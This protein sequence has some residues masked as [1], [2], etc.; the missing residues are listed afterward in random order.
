M[1]ILLLV[2]LASA[3]SGSGAG[4]SGDPYQITNCSQLQE[5]E[6]SLSSYYKLVNDIDCSDTINWDSGAGFDPIPHG[7]QGQLSGNGHKIINLFINRTSTPFGTGIALISSS[8]GTIKN[9]GLENAT[10]ISQSEMASTLV[11]RLYT[12]AKVEDCYA[13]GI[14]DSAGSAGGLVGNA[15]VSAE[16]SETSINNSYVKLSITCTHSSGGLVGISWGKVHNSFAIIDLN[17]SSYHIGGLMGIL[18]GAEILNCYSRGNVTSASINVGGIV[19]YVSSAGQITNT[20]TSTDIS[21]SS[22]TGGFIGKDVAGV[23]VT[24]SYWDNGTSG[25][26]NMCGSGTCSGAAGKTTAQMKQES[27][28]TNWDFT[29][30][31]SV[32]SCRNDGYPF[33]QLQSFSICPGDVVGDTSNLASV[34]TLSAGLTINLT[35]GSDTNG[36]IGNSGHSGIKNVVFKSSNQTLVSFN[37]NFTDTGLDLSKITINKSA[38]YIIFNSENQVTGKNI[39]MPF[40]SIPNGI[41]VKDA[42]ISSIGEI[43]STCSG[44]DET[45]FELSECDGNVNKNGITCVEVNSTMYTLT[46]LSNS[47]VTEGSIR[48]EILAVEANIFEDIA[49]KANYTNNSAAISNGNCNITFSNDIGNWYSMTF[50]GTGDGQYNYTN[51]FITAGAYTYNVTCQAPGVNALNTQEDITITDPTDVPEFSTWAIMLALSITIGGLICIR[52]R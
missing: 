26:S 25:L 41:C 38:N 22:N 48:L 1:C 10:I 29:D 8:Y 35:V 12:A 5:I 39:T 28:F 50:N 18:A 36:D 24:N 49:F 31:W 23:T 20:Y 40:S 47:A 30:T 42:E 37:L 9:L 19:G 44:S 45:S 27:T 13:T 17:A 43:S 7:F 21:G 2:P 51:S 46:N 33:L 11:G 6:D 16:G 3:F 15:G 32:Y 4:N 52:R 14:I 34:L